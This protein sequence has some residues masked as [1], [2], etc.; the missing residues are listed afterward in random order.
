[1]RSRPVELFS[2][3]IAAASRS[4]QSDRLTNSNCG[5][6]TLL[7]G[8]TDLRLPADESG[9]GRSNASTSSFSLEGLGALSLNK[10]KEAA[11]LRPIPAVELGGTTRSGL[12][13]EEDATGDGDLRSA[14]R[15]AVVGEA[16]R[17]GSG[18][19]GVREEGIVIALS[20]V[21]RVARWWGARQGRECR[22]SLSE[23]LEGS[24]PSPCQTRLRC[25]LCECARAGGGGNAKRRALEG[26]EDGDG[27][28]V[29]VGEGDGEGGHGD[30]CLSEPEP[31]EAVVIHERGSLCEE[32]DERE[33]LSGGVDENKKG[34]GERGDGGDIGRGKERWS[35]ADLGPRPRR[36]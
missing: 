25:A 6:L 26:P 28:V 7:T 33:G 23:P 1:M 9:L 21:L 4:G 10:S 19:L 30:G 36:R 22:V 11:T 29:M 35:C 20:E 8:A 12:E 3:R 17:K 27:A 14:A 34:E 18:F 15:R 2:L 24:T 16:G 5:S 13:E 31:S 32:W